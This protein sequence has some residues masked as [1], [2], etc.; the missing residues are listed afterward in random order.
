MAD[1]PRQKTGGRSHERLLL[2]VRAYSRRAA[3]GYQAQSNSPRGA[4]PARAVTCS[5]RPKEV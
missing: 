2:G 4:S 3:Q 5:L 1:A